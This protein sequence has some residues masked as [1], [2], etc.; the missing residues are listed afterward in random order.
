MNEELTKDHITITNKLKKASLEYKK[1]KDDWVEVEPKIELYS[2]EEDFKALKKAFKEGKTIHKGPWDNEPNEFSFIDEVTKLE[3][4]ILRNM[5]LGHLCGYVVFPEGKD[6]DLDSLSVHGGVT[7][8]DYQSRC[9]NKYCIGFDCAHYDDWS[10]YIMFRL[11]SNSV[12][13]TYKDIEFVKAECI[14]LAKQ[15]YDLRERE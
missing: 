13:S 2:F 1:D 10:P 5:E 12:D 8:S 6:Y 15:L 14:K 4:I 9:D 7:Y 3:C 11:F